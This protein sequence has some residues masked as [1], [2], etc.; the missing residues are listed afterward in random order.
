MNNIKGRLRIATAQFPVSKH[1]TRNLDYMVKL[2]KQAKQ[3]RA[4]IVHFSETCLGGYAGCEFTNWEEYDWPLLSQLEVEVPRLAKELGIHIVYGTNHRAA[5]ND[6]RNAQWYVSSSGKRVARYD[7]RFCTTGDLDFYKSGRRFT[8]FDINGFKCGLMICH[9]FRYPELFRAYKKR[10]VQVLLA[11]FY[12]ARA[13]GRGIHSIIC[14]PSLQGDAA[15]NH[16]YI[17]ANNSSGYYQSWPSLFILPD[18]T[19]PSTAPQHRTALLVN[20]ISTDD[21]YYDASEAFRDRAMR[22]VLYSK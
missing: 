16:L 12:N 10:G 20:E 11:S 2:A 15:S 6:V 1:L 5:K 8:T 7:K 14:R 21:E 19:V 17:S 13:K 22:G 4:D 9:D 3:Q 18:G